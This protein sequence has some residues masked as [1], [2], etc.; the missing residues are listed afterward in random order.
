MDV[1]DGGEAAQRGGASA[2]GDGAVQMGT[3]GVGLE[4]STDG[5]VGLGWG[6]A[7]AGAEG[8]TDTAAARAGAGMATRR[9]R[10]GASERLSRGARR[11]LAKAKKRT[12]TGGSTG[13]P[14][15]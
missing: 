8:S 10:T 11:K 6:A 7:E 2:E 5:A 12:A 9:Y 14:S 3:V 13:E 15:G 1:A 4:G